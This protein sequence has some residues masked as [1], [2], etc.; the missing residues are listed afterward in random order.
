MAR[1][2]PRCKSA[3]SEMLSF[4]IDLPATPAFGSIAVGFVAHL[5]H[6]PLPLRGLPIPREHTVTQVEQ[7]P[8]P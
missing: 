8:D 4:R 5:D 3:D 6:P 1:A 2:C 7:P